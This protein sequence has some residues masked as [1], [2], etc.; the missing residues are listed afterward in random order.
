MIIST[1]ECPVCHDIIWSR[2]DY[3]F[4]SCTCGA[5]SIDGGFSYV[6]ILWQGD[7][8][9]KP[10]KP[11]EIDLPITKQEAYDDWNKKINK[12]GTIKKLS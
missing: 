12:L 1:I 6:R 7:K 11:V 8:V 5:V 10:P 9:S 4:H 3:D 2:A